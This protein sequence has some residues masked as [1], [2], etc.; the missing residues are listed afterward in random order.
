MM[1]PLWVDVE[2]TDHAQLSEDIAVDVAIVGGGLTGIGAA[3]ALRSSR[4]RVALLEERSIGSGASG[5]N[6]GFVLAGPAVL[7]GDVV[8]VIGADAARGIWDLT[9]RNNRTLADLV[10]RYDIECGFLRCG[11]MSLA[12]SADEMMTLQRCHD[13][14][15]AAGI[16]T[17]MVRRDELP[18]PFDQMYAGGL[19]Y[20]GNGEM[21]S[22]AFVRGVGQAIAETVSLYEWSPVHQVTRDGSWVLQ[23]PG[24]NVRAEAVI[25]ASNAYTSRFIPAA[26][27]IPTRGQVLAT[28]PL[29]RV[30]VP[31]PMYANY[32]YQ[33]WRQTVDGRLVIGGWRDS[34]IDGEVGVDEQ[35]HEGIQGH[36]MDFA[37]VVAGNDV[38]IEYRWAGI[39]GFTP[40][41]FPLVGA[42]PGQP[43][44]YVAAGY[45]GHGVSMAFTCGSLVAELALGQTPGI[46]HAFRPDRY[47]SE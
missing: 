36:L 35:F 30:I 13:A 6:G 29:D 38:P 9:V 37:H 43:G 14:L 16:S 47:L 28:G 44:L 27:I 7:Y 10:V 11:S 18:V 46:P 32:G 33:Y 19:Y 45:S 22:G 3:Y 21:N 24:G 41:Q 26:P 20:P 34:D 4:L 12:I 5:R 25:F 31:F 2:R 23:T 39:M 40:D 17:A 15:T 8:D 42:V 1:R